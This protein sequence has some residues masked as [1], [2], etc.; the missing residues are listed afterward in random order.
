MI[1]LD[2]AATTRLAPEV[3]EEMLPYFSENYG[4]PGSV[5]SMGTAAKR[6]VNGSRESIADSMGAEAGEIYFTAGGTEADNW[7]LKAAALAHKGGHIITTRIEHH[8]VLRTCSYLEEKGFEVTWLDVDRYGMVRMEE[9]EAAVRPD[10]ILISVMFANNEIGTLEPIAEI[11][12]LAGKRGILFHTDA[13]QAYGQVPIRVR[14]LGIDL[15]SVSAHK[16]NGP[17]GVGCL[18]VRNGLKLGPFV[19]G[20]G[21]ER[22]RRAGTENVPGIVGFGAAAR[23]AVRNMGARTARETALR[24]YLLERL[25]KEIPDCRLNGHPRLRL[26]GNVNVSFSGIVGESLLIMLDM[27][28]I[29]ASSGAACTSGALEPSHVLLAIGLQEEEARGALRLTLSEENTKQE[30]DIAVQEIKQCVLRLR[31]MHI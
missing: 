17:K 2:N 1:Y 11:G 20:G 21:Q 6:A 31:E 12:A 13:V 29:C 15:M 22:S 27:K 7:A 3:L 10:T 4:N 30:L 5:C 24:D 25:L 18:Y 23:R 9:L 14:E 8:A 19:H 28:G 16:L 26:P